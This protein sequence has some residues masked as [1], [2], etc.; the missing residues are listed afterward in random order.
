MAKISSRAIIMLVIMIIFVVFFVNIIS[1]FTANYQSPEEKAIEEFNDFVKSLELKDRQN[2][3]VVF[4]AYVK[5]HTVNLPNSFVIYADRYQTSKMVL[6]VLYKVRIATDI[7]YD[8]LPEGY[9]NFKNKEFILND[10]VYTEIKRSPIHFD[11]KYGTSP[12]YLTRLEEATCASNNEIKGIIISPTEKDYCSVFSYYWKYNEESRSWRVDVP[13]LYIMEK[14][15][16]ATC[17]CTFKRQYERT[18][19]SSVCS[20]D[21]GE[22]FDKFPK[23]FVC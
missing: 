15:P 3:Y 7:D 4:D 21:F 14:D 8:S 22:M 13:I 6:F 1:A 19:S 10:L 17:S 12:D 9:G 16:D 23:A 20:S 2:K 5:T 18:K 11:D